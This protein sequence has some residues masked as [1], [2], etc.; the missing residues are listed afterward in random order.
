[1]IRK[2]YTVSLLVLAGL[3][4]SFS[5]AFAQMMSGT[6]S[7]EAEISGGKVSLSWE[8]PESFSVSYYLVYRGEMSLTDTSY[9]ISYGKIDSTTGTSY[10][11]S[12]TTSSSVAL[13]YQVRAFNASGQV[14]VSNYAK[15]FVNPFFLN[16]DQVTITSTP[17]LNGTVD[18]LYT[19][20][21]QAVSDS[22]SAVLHYRLGE[23][24]PMLM[25]I[26][27]TGLI[28]WVP[29]ARGWYEVTVVVVS[30]L[31]GRAKQEYAIR[32]AGING[33]IAGTVTDTTGNPIKKRPCQTLPE[34]YG[35]AF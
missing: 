13:V 34:G 24:H 25:T 10:Q 2:A 12:L 8:A 28:T 23:D 7:L 5:S 6:F 31:G 4:F 33:T 32:V 15:V 3:M 17:P 19:Y 27:S 20:Q 21:V 14:R 22:P 30:S 18:S 1:M 26:D 29:Q 35:L 16:R 11:D 9:N